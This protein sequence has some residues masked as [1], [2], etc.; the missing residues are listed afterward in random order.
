MTQ[1][2]TGIKD[3][4]KMI[5]DRTDDRSLFKLCQINKKYSEEL[6]NEKFWEKRVKE[7][8]WLIGRK[9]PE[10]MT[11]K[12]FYLSLIVIPYRKMLYRAKKQVTPESITIKAMD[13]LIAILD[14]IYEKIL[15]FDKSNFQES[16]VKLLGRNLG[17]HAMSFMRSESNQYFLPMDKRRIIEYLA[18]E[19]IELSILDKTGRITPNRIRAVFGKDED[20][21]KIFGKS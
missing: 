11:W 16:V 15:S 9:K 4:D 20:L 8:F 2:I 13:L 12:Q 1:S 5:I 6:C 3:L 10:N 18:E 19:I 7:R 17:L 14:P 21:G